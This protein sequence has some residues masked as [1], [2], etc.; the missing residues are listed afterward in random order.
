MYTNCL[1]PD[2]SLKIR[3]QW[4]RIRIKIVWIH[5]TDIFYVLPYSGFVCLLFTG[6]GG[7]AEK[8]M[9]NLCLTRLINVQ[10]KCKS[11][12]HIDQVLFL[13]AIKQ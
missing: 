3:I 10:W 8:K 5:I 7:R 1:D 13:P 12:S 2:P 9:T 4:I 6:A 11:K